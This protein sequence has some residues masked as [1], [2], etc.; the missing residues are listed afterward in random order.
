MDHR[1]EMGPVFVGSHSA[2]AD[3]KHVGIVPVSWTRLDFEA[4]L[5]VQDVEACPT[6]A[7][8]SGLPTIADVPGGAPKVSA[9]ALPQSQGL[10]YPT[11]KCSTQ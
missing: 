5:Q 3:L 10:A 1:A 8:S 11:R 6:V 4:I 7:L 2:V 9:Y